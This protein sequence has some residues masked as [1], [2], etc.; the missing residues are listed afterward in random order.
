VLLIL[1][2]FT[3]FRDR[4]LDGPRSV[5]GFQA[6]VHVSD[7]GF[8]PGAD[9]ESDVVIIDA[10]GAEVA[11]WRDEQ[12]GYGDDGAKQLLQSFIWLDGNTLQFRPVSRDV[13][14]LTTANQHTT[15]SEQD[16]GGKGEKRR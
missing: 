9:Y 7:R 4:V 1:A 10:G 3:I 11:R 2:Q 6:Q 12:G 16:G 14:T 15:T 8:G 5:A 13:M